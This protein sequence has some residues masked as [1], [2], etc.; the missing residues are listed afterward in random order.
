M[1][2]RNL[3]EWLEHIESLH[4]E[5][6]ELGLD[7]VNLVAGRLGFGKPEADTIVIAGTNGKG[8][9]S[10]LLEAM[11]LSAGKRVG[12]Y[13][14]PHLIAYNERIRVNGAPVSDDQLVEAFEAIAAVRGDVPLTYFEYGT[15]AAL[16]VFYSLEL[17]VLVLEVG[18][19]GRLDAV[20]IVDADLAIITS[21]SLDHES[22]L[23]SDRESI[24]REKAGILRPG[25]QA[26]IADPDPPRS[27]LES[28]QRLGCK[29]QLYSDKAG[30][31]LHGS[32]LRPENI[33]AAQAAARQLGFAPGGGEL[34]RLLQDLVVPGRLQQAE[35]QG[36]PVVLDVAHNPAAV[37]NLAS[38]LKS[39]VPGRRIALFAALSDKDIHA[40]IRPCSGVFEHWYVVGLPGVARAR[41]AGD[42]AE[43]VASAGLPLAAACGS[44]AEAW[45]QIL[46]EQAGATV[47][48]FGSFYT[49]GGFLELLGEGHIKA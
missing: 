33:F 39:S 24:G 48:I 4:P 41:K 25:I 34:E 40:M 1:P 7:R 31:S 21:I 2:M 13:T 20:N 30:E 3:G 36:V 18:L 49:V 8:S 26:V 10:A 6:I 22:W 29:A 23:G 42:L 17:D 16:Q 37:E 43:A 19:G 27:V 45:T 9:T 11:A 12:V 14:S 5:N 44:V 38:W 46:R 35:Y 28:L 47:V 15:L 32:R